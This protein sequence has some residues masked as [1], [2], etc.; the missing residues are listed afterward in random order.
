MGYATD[1]LAGSQ[2]L[3]QTRDHHACA[4]EVARHAYLL[5]WVVWGAD[6]YT[7][8]IKPASLTLHIHVMCL[9]QEGLV[10]LFASQGFACEDLVLHDKVVDNR[11]SGVRMPRKWIQAVF[12]YKGQTSARE[13]QE[14]ESQLEQQGLKLQQQQQLHQGQEQKEE[15]QQQV[16]QQWQAQ[17]EEQQEKQGAGQLCCSQEGCC[18][19]SSLP[20]ETQSTVLPISSPQKQSSGQNWQLGTVYPQGLDYAAIAAA[21]QGLDASCSGLRVRGSGSDSQPSSINVAG[22]LWHAP[23]PSSWIEGK[24]VLAKAVAL[25]QNLGYLHQ[26]CM[27]LLLPVSEEEVRARC[28]GPGGVDMSEDMRSQ[29]QQQQQ[30]Q[31]QLQ[32]RLSQQ[33]KSEKQQE[34][35]QRLE[36]QE[37]GQWQRQQQQPD[38]G[39][40]CVQ[41]SKYINGAAAAVLALTLVRHGARRVGVVLHDADYGAGFIDVL[42]LNEALVVRERVRYCWMVPGVDLRQATKTLQS[43][44][45]DGGGGVCVVACDAG[46]G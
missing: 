3:R 4:A 8:I 11:K 43:L 37:E 30:Q 32:P 16:Q 15:K 25:V 36:Q 21:I 9:P 42:H 6:H 24:G 26:L 40:G 13:P 20:A 44:Q 22:Q 1:N 46:A 14:A 33:Q 45:P 18:T 34:Q 41:N 28:F 7:L 10:E 19:V 17:K 27:V 35:Q 5:P 2:V 31:E 23:F 38:D 29:Q 12:R 39:G